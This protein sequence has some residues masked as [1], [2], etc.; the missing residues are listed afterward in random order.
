MIEFREFGPEH[1]A[2]EW[3]NRLRKFRDANFQQSY[4]FGELGKTPASDVFRA[5]LVDGD[6]TLVMAQGSIR[7]M[8]G[9]RVLAI[10]GGPVYRTSDNENRNLKHLRLFLQHLVQANKEWHRFFYINVTM[11]GERSALTE[12]ALREAGMT[13]PY[14]ERV[15]YLTYMLPIHRDADRN[16]KAFDVKW[17]NQL[18]RAESLEPAFAWGND[19]SLIE[20]YVALHNAMCRIKSIRSYSITPESISAMRRH[21]GERLQFVIGSEAGQDVCGCAVVI[22]HGKAYY[23]YAAANEQGRNGY[24][25]NAMV[26]FLIRKLRELDVAEMDMSGIDPARNWGG[27]H[28]KK[29]TGGRLFAYMGEWDHGSPGFLKPLM[30]IALYLR[31]KK[32]YR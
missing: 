29:G 11:N 24:F 4:S 16:M 18:R 26:W 25:S 6:Q 21:L 2:E 13:R 10:R 3:D 1:P 17:R 23:Y 8:F 28:F 12:I 5:V 27:Y 15:P 20:S 9:I 30:N 22:D 14:F 7:K 31:S 32:M 19:D